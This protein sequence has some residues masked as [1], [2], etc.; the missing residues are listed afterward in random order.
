MARKNRKKEPWEEEE[1]EI[2]WVSRSELKRDMEDLQK[3]GKELVELKPAVL[4]KFP[5]EDSLLAAISDAQR[6]EK[7]AKRRQLQYIGKLMRN[8]DPEPIQAAL[9]KHN[10]KHNQQAIEFQ[11]LERM[12]DKIVTDGDSA[13]NDVVAMFPNADRQKLR[14][15][16]R[17]AKK[18][19]EHNK[20]AKA[21]KEIFQHLKSLKKD[22]EE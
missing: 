12:R 7:E 13:I 4:K 3:L 10:N 5:L 21:F 18:E 6:F 15:L 17:Q 11:K 1:E 14:Q 8:I 20:P 22:D 9:D 19:Q 16:A 2:I